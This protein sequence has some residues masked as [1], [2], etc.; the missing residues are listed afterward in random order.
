M[1][2]LIRTEFPGV[3]RRGWRYVVVYRDG[4]RQC[5]QSAATLL[6]A[7]AVKLERDAQA[8]EQRRGP[9]LHAHALDW[10]D[11]YAGSGHDS[12]PENTRRD[13]RRL[14]V[15]FALTYFDREVRLGDLDRAQMQQFIDWLI[16]RPGGDGRLRDQS[17]AN[18]ITPLR[19]AL[20]AAV[21][22]GLLA[23]SP[24]A[25][26]CCRAGARAARGR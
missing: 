1:L 16:T 10:L 25:G 24:F 4:G 9:T 22:E 23:T 12:V 2:P 18:A 21:A 7:R 20:D 5:K 6:E 8:R 15:S 26:P 11:R 19:L 3:Y 13:Y 17:I 14:L